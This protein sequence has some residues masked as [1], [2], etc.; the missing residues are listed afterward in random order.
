MNPDSGYPDE[1]LK[2]ILRGVVDDPAGLYKT[3]L[4]PLIPLML[5]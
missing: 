3:H 1:D 4:V 2:A 5:G